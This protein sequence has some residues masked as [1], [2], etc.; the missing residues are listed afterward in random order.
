MPWVYSVI[1]VCVG[2]FFY[3]L[4]NHYRAWYGLSEL[5]VAFVLMYVMYFPHGSGVL[6]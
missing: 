3:W 2:L 5:I 6:F 1:T 4:R